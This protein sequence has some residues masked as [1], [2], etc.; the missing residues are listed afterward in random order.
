MLGKDIVLSVKPQYVKKIL[1]I[2]DFG[3]QSFLAG[4]SHNHR[5][6]IS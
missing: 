4:Q 3:V 5:I 6:E 2:T 1:I